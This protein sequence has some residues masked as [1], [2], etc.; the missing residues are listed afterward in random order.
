VIAVRP[1]T[2]ADVPVLRELL[3]RV[4]AEPPDDRH[5]PIE[6]DEVHLLLAGFEQMLG[7]PGNAPC[8]MLLA[9]APDTQQPIGWVTMRGADR[10]RIRHQ[11]VLGISVDRD[12]RGRGIG[13]AL[14][15]AAIAWARD[16]RLD[17]IEL[18]VMTRNRAGVALY[19]KMGFE[20]EGIIRAGIR[21]GDTLHDDHVMGLLLR[22][23]LVS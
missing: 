13:R 9:L 12:Y 14:M 6:P 20:H 16:V 18:R 1:A 21:I 3:A 10:A 15:A 22:Y 23:D 17:R 5:V 11:A 2:L 8:C 7:K 4:A 19:E